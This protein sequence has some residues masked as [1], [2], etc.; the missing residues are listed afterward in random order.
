MKKVSASYFT[1]DYVQPDIIAE[2]EKAYVV[3]PVSSLLVLETQKDY[4]R[5]NIADSKNSLKNA[6]IKSSGS[7]PEPHEW[8]LIVLFISIVI[9]LKF[10][11]K[12]AGYDY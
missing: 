9:Y 8:L 10:Y 12:K 4:E 1:N 3:T 11:T 2:A 7:V 5:F 6:S